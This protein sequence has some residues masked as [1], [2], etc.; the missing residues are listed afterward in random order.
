M[1]QIKIYLEKKIEACQ[2]SISSRQIQYNKQKKFDEIAYE[3]MVRQHKE[4]VESRAATHNR[5]QK[6]SFLK[7]E[8]LKKEI[9]K[10]DESVVD[11]ENL[12]LSTLMSNYE[13]SVVVKSEKLD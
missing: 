8:C 10:V 9:I 4:K 3:K 1:N 7:I 11:L 12:E 5:L 13:L 2:I 6:G